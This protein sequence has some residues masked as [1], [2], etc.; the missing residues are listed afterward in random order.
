MGEGVQCPYRIQQDTQTNQRQAAQAGP[1]PWKPGDPEMEPGSPM[2]PA[3]QSNSFPLNNR[4]LGWGYCQIRGEGP[5]PQTNISQFTLPQHS[6]LLAARL[7]P[8]ALVP[9]LCFSSDPQQILLV[10]L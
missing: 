1:S 3:S 10:L 2:P 9:R 4:E 8:A 7:Q 6:H 5:R